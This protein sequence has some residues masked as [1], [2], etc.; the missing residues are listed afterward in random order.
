MKPTGWRMLI[1]SNDYLPPNL[2]G[3]SHADWPWPL[4]LVPR[5]WTAFNWGNP[6]M[7]DGT[8]KSVKI[9]DGQAYPKPI[10]EPGSWQK[11]CYPDLPGFLGKLPLYYARTDEA[12]NHF[13]WGA[14]WDD[15]DFY[16]QAPTVAW[17]KDVE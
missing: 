8:Q 13:R 1:P 6:K 7:L 17:K 14:R 2:Q 15:T 3:K 5:K 10:G 4:S 11:S 12:G 9:I 16:T